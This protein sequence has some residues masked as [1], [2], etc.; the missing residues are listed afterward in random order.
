MEKLKD[1]YKDYLAKVITAEEAMLQIRKTYLL[2]DEELSEEGL[3][4][5][6]HDYGIYQLKENGEYLT[7]GSE[8][9]CLER[10][11]EILFK[12][13]TYHGWTGT[14]EG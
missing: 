2:T 9:E 11:S 14:T 7:E 12:N 4:I 8:T 5:N 1:I 6:Y 13:K 3:T 10:A